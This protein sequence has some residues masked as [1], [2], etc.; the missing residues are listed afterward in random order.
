MKNG[1]AA[2]PAAM[3]PQ[4]NHQWIGRTDERGNRQEIGARAGQKG[5][6]RIR[7]HSSWR[8]DSVRIVRQSDYL[9]RANPL[10]DFEPH[11][12]L[13]T[14]SRFTFEVAGNSGDQHISSV[15]AKKWLRGKYEDGRKKY[16]KAGEA[17][18]AQ[19]TPD[20]RVRQNS[21]SHCTAI[22]IPAHRLLS[23]RYHFAM[24]K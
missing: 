12:H 18:F 23:Y 10:Q 15:R 7:G 21:R 19:R 14:V 11:L 4:N 5:Q 9:F 2:L 17:K 16:E 22:K 3:A 6:R 1:C 8:A 24:G 13:V 20:A